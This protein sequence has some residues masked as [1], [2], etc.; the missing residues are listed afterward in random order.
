MN[1]KIASDQ[2]KKAVPVWTFDSSNIFIPPRDP[3]TK[4]PAIGLTT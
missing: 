1:P 3:V 4:G 2:A